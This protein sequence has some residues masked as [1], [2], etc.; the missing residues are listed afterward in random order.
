MKE[1]FEILNEDDLKIKYEDIIKDL[2]EN[3]EKAVTSELKDAICISV[4]GSGKT[5]VLT[6]RVAYLLYKGVKEDEIM[7]LT[8]TTKA[9]NVMLQRVKDL[10]KRS[11]LKVL[12]GTFHHV[13]TF[14]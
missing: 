7:L 14:F 9:A 13:A 1:T 12:G 8:F 6:R 10:L 3:Q 5:R 4:A 11:D 2:D